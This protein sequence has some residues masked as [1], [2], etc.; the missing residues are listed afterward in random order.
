MNKQLYDRSSCAN[1]APSSDRFRHFLSD[2]GTLVYIVIN[3]LFNL[4][5]IYLLSNLT[6]ESQKS[7]KMLLSLKLPLVVRV[8]LGYQVDHTKC[9]PGGEFSR[10]YMTSVGV[11]CTIDF[12]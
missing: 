7:D 1:V 5:H 2:G 6:I 4:G 12:A 8:I 10:H 3:S 9:E 11:E